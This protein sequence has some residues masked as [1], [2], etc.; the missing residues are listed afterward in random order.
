MI[1]SSFFLLLHKNRYVRTTFMLSFYSKKINIFFIFS[2][3]M[4]NHRL[5]ISHLSYTSSNSS[6][7]SS[8]PS[9]NRS[10]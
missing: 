8:I 1:S 3:I 4:Y 10:P 9:S 5:L 7:I 2:Y 6:K